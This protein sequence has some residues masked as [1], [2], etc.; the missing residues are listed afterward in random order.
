MDTVGTGLLSIVGRLSLYRRVLNVY[1]TIGCGQVVC[2]FYGGCPLL[3]LSIIGVPLY[4]YCSL[5]PRPSP[6]RER[7]GQKYHVIL[8]S[9]DTTYLFYLL[10]FFRCPTVVVCSV[11]FRLQ[12]NPSVRTLYNV[13]SVYT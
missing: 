13:H 1:A 12:N 6:Q 3:R 8:W 7:P 10:I 11:S 5:V 9:C 4:I 2:P